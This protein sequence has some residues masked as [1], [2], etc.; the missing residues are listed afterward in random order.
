MTSTGMMESALSYYIDKNPELRREVVMV[1]RRFFFKLLA[2]Q[3]FEKAFRLALDLA[4]EDI[5]M[6][7]A[8]LNVMITLVSVTLQ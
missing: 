4:T 1:M 2:S 3:S 7:S 5:F 6:V 8:S